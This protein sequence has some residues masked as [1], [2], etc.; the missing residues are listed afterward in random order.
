MVIAKTARCSNCCAGMGLFVMSRR[1]C[2]LVTLAAAL[3]AAGCQQRRVVSTSEAFDARAAA[4][5]LAPGDNTIR[6]SAFMRKLTG[7]I[8]PAAGEV[9]RL[10]PATELAQA[11]FRAIYGP[12]KRAEAQRV[13]DFESTPDD[14]VRLTRTTKADKAGNFEFENVRPGRYFVQS[15]VYWYERVAGGIGFAYQIYDEVTVKG[16]GQTVEVV[17]SGN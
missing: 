4:A 14:Y 6:G 12:N 10:V 7:S 3:L 16:S 1:L 5:A 2:V 8:V 17:L 15:R 9:V 13:P 11:R